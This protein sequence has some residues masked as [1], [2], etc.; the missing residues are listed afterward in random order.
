MG[1]QGRTPGVGF[2]E[3]WDI[4]RVGVARA[5]TL[6]NRVLFPPIPLKSCWLELA[7][8]RLKLCMAPGPRV[9]SEVRQALC[10]AARDHLTV[11]RSGLRSRSV[12]ILKVTWMILCI[13]LR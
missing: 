9:P 6:S 3:E 13:M 5:S 4:V 1:N 12:I 11:K 10:Q 8:S 7:S 2:T